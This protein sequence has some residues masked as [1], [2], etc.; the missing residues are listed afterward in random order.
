MKKLL[1]AVA[2]ALATSGANAMDCEPIVKWPEGMPQWVCT[3]AYAEH[4][5]AFWAF[6]GVTLHPVINLRPTFFMKRAKC[7]WLA[8]KDARV[9]VAYQTYVTWKQPWP[10]N[11]VVT[12]PRPF[13]LRWLMYQC[14]YSGIQL[15]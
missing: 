7:T 12:E 1:P 6:A 10:S 9:Y 14:P 13:D 4:D 5:C 8:R 15:P 2:L 3:S 11:K